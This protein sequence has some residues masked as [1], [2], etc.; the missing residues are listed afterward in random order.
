MKNLDES[1]KEK[2]SRGEPIPI[3]TGEPPPQVPQTPQGVLSKQQADELRERWNTIQTA[4][5]DE[6]RRS[7][8]DADA[9]VASATKQIT[10]AFANQRSE[11]EKQW[12]RGDQV[13][14]EELRITLQQYRT[15]FSRL[16]AMCRLA[17]AER[18]SEAGA[19]NL[20]E[21]G[22]FVVGL[23]V[24]IGLVQQNHLRSCASHNSLRGTHIQ[25]SRIP[26]LE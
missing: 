16:L 8:K 4:F 14:T 18:H 13:S 5:I 11:L 24:F 12:S 20:A 2:E 22:P 1:L 3:R 9:L 6:P 25:N 26:S 23:I 7:V 10:D 15:F 19:R 17:R 21:R